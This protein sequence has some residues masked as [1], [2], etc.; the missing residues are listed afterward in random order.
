MSIYGELSGKIFDTDLSLVEATYIY[1]RCPCLASP[2]DYASL[3]AQTSWA[4]KASIREEKRREK[5]SKQRNKRKRLNCFHILCGAT[6]ELILHR[7]SISMGCI[8]RRRSLRNHQCGRDLPL[9]NLHQWELLLVASVLAF[10]IHR[11]GTSIAW[12]VVASHS[13]PSSQ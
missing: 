10:G 5:R 1:W 9:E 4:A 8:S 3:Y 13:L 11:S 12:Y 7:P 6:S 2:L